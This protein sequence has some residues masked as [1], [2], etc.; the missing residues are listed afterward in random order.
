MDRGL[1]WHC[2]MMWHECF[3]PGLNLAGQQDV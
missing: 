1:A 2:A 3:V